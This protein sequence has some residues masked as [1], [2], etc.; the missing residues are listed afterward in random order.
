MSVMFRKYNECEWFVKIREGML[1][2]RQH[3]NLI[4]YKMYAGPRHEP[5]DFNDE[6]DMRQGPG[7]RSVFN[8]TSVS[9]SYDASPV[10]PFHFLNQ[11]T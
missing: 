6:H 7:V 4:R 2:R 11:V 8:K 1:S 10:R 3:P 5:R 9:P